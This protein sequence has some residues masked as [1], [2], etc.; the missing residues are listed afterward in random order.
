MY[1]Y[2]CCKTEEKHKYFDFFICSNI[3]EALIIVTSGGPVAMP[4]PTSWQFTC[5]KAFGI[6]V[7]GLSYVPGTA[8]VSSAIG[9][10]VI[11][12]LQSNSRQKFLH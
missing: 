6:A 1:L 11:S 2:F 9:A 12:C 5:L 7:N 10:Q 8:L 4:P 3:F